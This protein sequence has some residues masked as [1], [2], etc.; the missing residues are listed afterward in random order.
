MTEDQLLGFKTGYLLGIVRCYFKIKY[1]DKTESYSCV[2]L[3]MDSRAFL[4]MEVMALFCKLS[5]LTW[6]RPRKA[7]WAMDLILLF[8]SSSLVRAV[9]PVNAPFMS[10]IVHD[11][12][13]LFSSLSN[14]HIRSIQI[15]NNIVM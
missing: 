15:H 7:F 12:A 2:S 1:G 13:L 9:S 4:C 11:M 14:A 6:P 8:S 10:S 3:L 5:T